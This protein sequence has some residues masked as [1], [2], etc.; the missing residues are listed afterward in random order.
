MNLEIAQSLARQ[1]VQTAHGAAEMCEVC[2]RL[3]LALAYLPHP[4]NSEQGHTLLPIL[5]HQLTLDLFKIYCLLQASFCPQL[6]CLGARRAS[7]ES[8]LCAKALLEWA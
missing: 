3:Q 5:S 4:P 1:L 8:L 6:E 2:S 7:R